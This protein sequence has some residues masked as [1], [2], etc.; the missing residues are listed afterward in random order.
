MCP[1][2]MATDSSNSSSVTD[3]EHEHANIMRDRNQSNYPVAHSLPIDMPLEINRQGGP[4]GEGD[5]PV[6]IKQMIFFI[7]LYYRCTP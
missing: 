3:H 6:S 1:V 4:A 7:V 5:R 2:A